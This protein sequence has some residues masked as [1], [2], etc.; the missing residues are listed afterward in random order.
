MS[1][2]SHRTLVTL[3]MGIVVANTLNIPGSWKV[4]FGIVFGLGIVAIVFLGRAEER[5]EK[6]HAY[7]EVVK[8]DFEQTGTSL[9]RSPSLVETDSSG[10]NMSGIVRPRQRR[11]RVRATTITP[12]VGQNDSDSTL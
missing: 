11:S 4:F 8:K 9:F 3:A 6:A 1:F 12:S 2:R 5:G 7:H 10:E